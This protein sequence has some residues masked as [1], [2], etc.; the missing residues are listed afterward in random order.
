MKWRIYYYD[1]STFSDSEGQPEDAPADGIQV[2]VQEDERAGRACIEGKDFYV[3][4]GE[5]WVGMD[6][7]G[8]KTWLRLRG[9]LKHGVTVSRRRF[10]ETLRRALDD[11]DFPVKS[12]RYRDEREV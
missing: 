4:D 5:R 12:K 8:M 11:S 3:F 9:I 2:I 6:G 1:G 10:D 7:D